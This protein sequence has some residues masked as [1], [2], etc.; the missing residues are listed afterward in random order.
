MVNFDD[1]KNMFEVITNNGLFFDH[2][3]CGLKRN[4]NQNR[5]RYMCMKQQIIDKFTKI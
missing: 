2:V 1:N 4:P 3:A 5:D